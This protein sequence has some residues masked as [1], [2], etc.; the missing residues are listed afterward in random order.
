MYFWKGDNNWYSAQYYKR[1][2]SGK[3]FPFRPMSWPVTTSYFIW[4]WFPQIQPSPFRE[5]VTG[6]AAYSALLTS[7]LWLKERC[8]S[9][10]V[11]FFNVGVG[12]NVRVVCAGS[13]DICS[14][15]PREVV[16]LPPPCGAVSWALTARHPTWPLP[17]WQKWHLVQIC[18]VPVT[19]Q[20]ENLFIFWPFVFFGFLSSFLS[21]FMFIFCCCDRN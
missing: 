18:I 19:Q 15:L 6:L 5:W 13:T 10:S 11:C 21:R 20:I 4:K 9:C 16:A 17:S 1:V 12:T 8:L 14:L 7:V 2:K 3:S